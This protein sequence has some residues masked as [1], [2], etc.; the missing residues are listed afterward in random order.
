MKKNKT[1]Y[2]IA[3]LLTLTLFL[4]C[5]DDDL[6]P[7]SFLPTGD[8]FEEVNVT[9]DL[10]RT[11]SA[12][13]D[14]IPATIT[15][16]RTFDVDANVVLR[17]DLRSNAFTLT[18]IT[19]PAGSTSATGLIATPGE[20]GFL[21]EDFNEPGTVTATSIGADD[22]NGAIYIAVS[23][24]AS[25]SLLNAF[26]SS[27][28]VG[29]ISMTFF[30]DSNDNYDLFY[31]NSGNQG[32]TGSSF[33]VIQLTNE[34]VSGD[35]TTQVVVDPINIEGLVDVPYV[36]VVRNSRPFGD[37]EITVLEGTL[38]TTDN[39]LFILAEITRTTTIDNSNP[40][41]P[42]TNFDYVIEQI[43]D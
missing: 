6:G 42:I 8:A 1:F 12:E 23:N 26:P 36:L 3:S 20:D 25:F 37:D 14:E 16:S 21:F 5:D 13:G 27:I 40:D 2:L 7:E 35:G 29:G 30:W 33:E 39:S 11:I 10:Q 34:E 15:L 32:A 22:G 41:A 38:D 43:E 18:T 19:V 28:V 31:D 9:I 17:T 24:E 4:S